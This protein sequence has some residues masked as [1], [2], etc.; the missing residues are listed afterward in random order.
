MKFKFPKRNSFSFKERFSYWFDNK[1]AKSSLGFIQ[2]LIIAFVLFAVIIA[3]L[4]ILFR[5]NEEGEVASVFWDSIATLINAWMPSFADGSL[6]YLV[7]M[8]IIAIAGLLYT[9]V[10][11][12][13]ITSAIEQKID[14]LKRGNSFVLEKDHIVVLGFYPGEYTLLNQLVLAAA[15]KPTCIVVTEDMD[16]ADME[17]D[18]LENITLPRNV[19]IVCRT[20]DI[21][22][23]L[24]IEKCSIETCKTV[25]VSPTDDMRTLK[26][27]L[28]VSVLIAEKEASGV[29]VTAIISKEEFRFPSSLARAY[30]VSTLQANTIIGKMIA[31]SCTQTGLSAAFRELF[32]FAGSEFYLINLKGIDGLSFREL[33]VR[34]NHAVPVG[35]LRDGKILLNPGADFLF[36]DTDKLLVFSQERNDAVLSEVRPHEEMRMPVLTVKPE[37]ATDVVIFGFNETLPVLLDELP[38]NVLS[39]DLIPGEIS[40]EEKERLDEIASARGLSLSYHE[41]DMRSESDLLALV[42]TAKHA[43]ILN[44]HEKDPEEA[45][46]EV[47][48]LLLNL[49]DIRSIYGLHYNITVEMQKEHNH[50]L[51]GYGDH[52]DFLVSANIS[53]LILAQ[54]AE[55]PGLMEVFEEIL[56]NEGNELYLKSAE[57][58]GLEGK[59]LIRDLRLLVL[60]QGYVLLGILDEGKN[61]HFHLLPDEEVLLTGRD[62]LIVIGES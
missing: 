42:R 48:F 39:A 16:R 7:M 53:S 19:R 58:L 28:A 56:A 52:T 57:R 35:A 47:I 5:F 43:V 30:S 45:D 61:S 6:G 1:M 29:K 14:N 18:I 54:L 31:H 8:S 9:S 38:E 36:R 20:S 26:A 27:V 2:F 60:S 49:S 17:Q 10:L 44:N 33:T 40:E 50:K 4:I 41:A 12:G 34:L 59:Y 37:E 62:S 32:D 21:T 24:S 15:D 51:V 23:P 46:M 25:V 11:I 22:D 3:S 55:S 13:I